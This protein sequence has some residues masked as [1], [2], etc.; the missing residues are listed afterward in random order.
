MGNIVKIG[1]S[2]GKDSTCSVIKHIERG[3]KV[4]IVTYIP[5]FTDDI[6]LILKDHYNFIMETSKKFIEMGCEFHLVKGITYYDYVT[7]PILRGPNKGKIY[8]FPCI[9][10]GKCGFNRDSKSKACNNF[11]VGEFDYTSVGIAYDEK[12]RHKQLNDKK[13]SI[14]VELQ[15]TEKQAL[16]YC[17]SVDLLSPIYKKGLKRDGCG[18]CPQASEF[19][20]GLWFN[21]YPE[22]I[23]LVIELQNLVKEKFPERAPLRNRKYFI[24]G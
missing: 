6:P 12:K 13:R 22:A 24:D 14:L 1:W 2:G 10:A 19:E 3:D 5:M 11:D 9:L 4:K 17:K 8:A 16:E 23:P 21:D 15:I 18:L 7:R 20:R